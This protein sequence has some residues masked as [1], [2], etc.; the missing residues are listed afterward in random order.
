MDVLYFETIRC[1]NGFAKNLFFHKKRILDTIS[2][3]L[4]IEE[5]IYPPSDEFLKCKII[6]NK[7]GILEIKYSQYQKKKINSLKLIKSNIKYN[8]KYLNR[9]KIN[10]LFKLKEDCD[11]ILIVDDKGFLKD[12]SIANIA[13]YINNVWLTPRNPLLFGTTVARFVEK[14]R[15]FLAEL[16]IDDL[17]N[18][19]GFALLNSMIDFDIIKK[20]KIKGI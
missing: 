16:K 8:K 1:E 12:T 10:E 20:I 6:Y 9:D 17:K 7:N 18:A 4:P 3:E 15:I 13:L 19:K 14:K 11:D 5:Y 2:L